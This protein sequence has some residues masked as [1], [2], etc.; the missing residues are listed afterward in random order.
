MVREKMA[1]HL[2]AGVTVLI[3]G[4]TFISSKK[5][6]HLLSPAEL[7]FFRFL[8]GYAGLTLL[9]PLPLKWTGARREGL[10]ALAG[11][12]GVCLYFMLQNIALTKTLAS[13]VGIIVSVAP[14]FTAVLSRFLQKGGARLPAGFL[15]GFFLA[16]A[17]IVLVSL[18]GAGP[19]LSPAGDFLAVLA[20]LAWAVYSI[21]CRAVGRWG[22]GTVASTR[23]V[24]FYG[25]L[26]MLPFAL[27]FKT[28]VP[29]LFHGESLFHLLFLGLGASA[30]CFVT[31]SAAV[32]RLGAVTSS[33][34]IYASPVITVVTSVLFLGEP[35][36]ARSALGIA[37]ILSG[38]IL[39]GK[40]PV[41]EKAA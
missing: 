23:R 17:G 5:L 9:H 32:L 38:L 28:D 11:L 24:F 30:V 14:F 33:V 18:S 10:F 16:M 40:Y 3:W 8:I 21:L 36:T 20:A 34:Y 2:A 25:L 22:Y 37:L 12:C 19:V 26:F 31:W 39:S 15:I 6:L 27:D 4:M 13:N 29:K 41:K 1:G 35:L 7:M